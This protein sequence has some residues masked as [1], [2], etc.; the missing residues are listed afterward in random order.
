LR[1]SSQEQLVRAV[2]FTDTVPLGLEVGQLDPRCSLDGGALSCDPGDWEPG[3]RETMMIPVIVGQACLDDALRPQDSPSL[4][5]GVASNVLTNTT[6]TLDNF[7][8]IS[9][10]EEFLEVL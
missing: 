3:A 10:R 9:S 8:R 2:T 7:R 1:N 4:T 6:F 5:T